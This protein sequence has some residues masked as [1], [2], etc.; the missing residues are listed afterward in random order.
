MKVATIFAIIGQLILLVWSVMSRFLYE[1]DGI[2]F[3]VIGYLWIVVAI[4]SGG[5]LIAF[6]ITFLSAFDKIERE[7]N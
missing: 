5:T 1:I 3:E 6:F 2:N 7:L 4:F